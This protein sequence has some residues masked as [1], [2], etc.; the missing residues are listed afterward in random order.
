MRFL[1]SESVATLPPFSPIEGQKWFDQISSQ[2]ESQKNRFALIYFGKIQFLPPCIW[3]LPFMSTASENDLNS[4]FT[5]QSMSALFNFT[6]H[7]NGCAR[8]QRRHTRCW[9]T[10]T[11]RWILA[12]ISTILPAADSSVEQSFPMTDPPG[13]RR[14]KCIIPSTDRPGNRRLK[15]TIPATD[16]LGIRRLKSKNLTV[17]RSGNRRFKGTI[18]NFISFQN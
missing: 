11:E 14:L 8:M 9:R 1:H 16:S 6:R 13:N 10:W 2:W 3:N 7:F 17:D 15:R 5:R 12:T 18:P 4:I